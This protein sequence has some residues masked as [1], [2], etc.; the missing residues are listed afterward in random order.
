MKHSSPAALPV[1]IFC[2]T[3]ST[4]TPAPKKTLSTMPERRVFLEPREVADREHRQHAEHAG[5]DRAGQQHRQRFPVAAQ[6]R[7]R[8]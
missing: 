3:P 5:D 7:R 1:P 8:R 4:A 6:R 2:T